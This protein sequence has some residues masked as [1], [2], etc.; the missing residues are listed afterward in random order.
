MAEEIFKCG[1]WPCLSGGNLHCKFGAI[2]IKYQSYGCMKIT[3]LLFLSIHT[4]SI[5]TCPVFLGHM[6]FVLILITLN[7]L[8][9]CFK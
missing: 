1:M 6:N 8:N 7:K 4:H 9:I 3:S 5:C 2:W